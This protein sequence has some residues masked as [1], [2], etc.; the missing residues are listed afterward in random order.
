MTD[1]EGNPY[2]LPMNFG[3]KDGVIYIHGAQKGKK[4]D[5]LKVNPQVCV[6]FSTDHQLRFQSEEV[7]CSW[8]MRYRSVL[9]YGRVEFITDPTEKISALDIVMAQYSD[10]SFRYNP[11][12]IR[13]V[14][15]WKIKVDRFEGRI[16]GY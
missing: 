6:N 11:P 14:N 16:F 7:A 10:R 5:I 4:I 3:F 8:S 9:A 12:S 13:E 2:L 1:L 15:V